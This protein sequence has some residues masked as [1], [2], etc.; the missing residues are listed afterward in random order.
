MNSASDKPG[1]VPLDVPGRL[2]D[3]RRACRSR[4]FALQRRVDRK[5][6]RQQEQGGDRL[7]I[8][9]RIERQRL[10]QMLARWIDRS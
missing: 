4:L 7:E 2:I 8:A 1:T 10:V 6:L 5:N 3:K 9:L